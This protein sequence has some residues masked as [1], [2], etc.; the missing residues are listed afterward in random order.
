MFEKTLGEFHI[1]QLLSDFM[2]EFL[3]L[4][5]SYVT[6]SQPFQSKLNF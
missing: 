6:L 2:I 4:L 1:G 5:F 3:T